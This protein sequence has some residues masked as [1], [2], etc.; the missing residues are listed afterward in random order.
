MKLFEY[1]MIIIVITG[2]LPV[3][4]LLAI[5]LFVALVMDNNNKIMIGGH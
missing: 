3:F 4:I 2:L 1:A 5:I